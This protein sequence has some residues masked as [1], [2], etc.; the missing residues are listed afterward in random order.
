MEKNVT[1][2]SDAFCQILFRTYN[3]FVGN[4]IGEGSNLGITVADRVD[5]FGLS[6]TGVTGTSFF[7][8]YMSGTV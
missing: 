6:V 7:L 4:N 3:G 5:L 2:Q 1:A 8:G